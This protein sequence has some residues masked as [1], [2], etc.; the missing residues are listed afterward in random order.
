MSALAMPTLSPL[1]RRGL[2]AGLLGAGGIGAT[3]LLIPRGPTPPDPKAPPPEI[4]V[5]SE[6]LRV[7]ED[8]LTE[9][10][11]DVVR[12]YAAAPVQLKLPD[13]SKRE[14]TRSA[15]GAEI[16]KAYLAELV[17]QAKDPRSAMRR[18][19]AMREKRDAIVLPTGVL[20]NSTQAIKAL[21][22]LKEELDR[23]A[24]DARL[25]LD[26]RK[27]V[28]ERDGY[29]IDVYATLARLDEA[30]ARGDREVTVAAEV[31]EPQVHAKGIGDVTF[32]SVL[33]WFETRYSPDKR[34]EA[35][36]YNLRLAASKLD[37]H[38]LMPG[39]VFDFNKLVGPR[40]E[41][42]GYKVA[43]VIAQGEL[44]DGIGGGTCQITGTL[45]GAVFFAG[46]EITNRT[47]HTRPSGY[48][49]MGLDAAVAYPTI[50]F[51]FKN[52]LPFPVVLHETVKDGVVRA[53]ILGPTRTR[54]VTFIRR[55]D[56]IIPY[57]EQERP[58]PK[59]PEG[60]RVLSQRG[61][62]GFKLHRY[63]VVREGPFAVRERFVD[64][65][66]P[67]TQIIRV[68]TGTG[69]GLATPA[70]DGHPE[71]TADE[72]LSLTQGPG[73]RAGTEDGIIESRDPG[74]TGSVGWTE[75]AGLPVW[76]SKRRDDKP[77]KRD[78]AD[79]ADKD[80]ADRS[81]KKARADKDEKRP[82]EGGTRKKKPRK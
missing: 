14:L 60:V 76:D 49:K 37:G 1:A 5:A 40:N 21:L 52:T 26:S 68:G 24:E 15:L 59:I 44:V 65:Y 17:T 33:G 63:R 80:A 81:D 77:D 16:D 30:L 43:P 46:L 35:R 20:V 62:P 45:H 70:D 4:V 2:Q 41:A 72:M 69:D 48:I 73:A 36:T 7:T 31:V 64:T 28:P 39:A 6:R 56:E 11:L 18:E 8:R 79:K 57:Q 9:R 32:D 78:S 74:R 3:L 54:T 10:V 19:H 34:H 58:D 66:P 12:R 23:H 50:N 47:P 22:A 71:Y 38:V 27:L 42:R 29:R 13:G 55:I 67:T 61:V 75:K 53:E 82:T 51:K 25:D